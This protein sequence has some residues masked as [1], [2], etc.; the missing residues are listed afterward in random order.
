[1]NASG[2]QG[3]AGNISAPLGVAEINEALAAIGGYRLAAPGPA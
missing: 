3:T 1:M 2:N